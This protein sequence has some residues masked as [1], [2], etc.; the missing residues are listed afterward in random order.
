MASRCLFEKG[1]RSRLTAELES[2]E[3]IGE[4]LR[5]C[6]RDLMK[7][8]A[9]DMNA[10]AHDAQEQIRQATLKE[11]KEYNELMEQIHQMTLAWTKE[12][13][14]WE[15]EREALSKEGR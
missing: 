1:D 2:S 11:R 7:K 15:T 14:M 8:H 13:K 4:L 3:I 6:T 10:F 12:R 9:E 5:N